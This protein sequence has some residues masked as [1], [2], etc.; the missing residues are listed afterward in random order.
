LTKFEYL[1]P[2][3]VEEASELLM[4]YGE[5]AKIFNGG[6]DLLVRMRESLLKPEYL[7]DIKSISGMS[8]IKYLDGEGLFLGASVTMNQLTDSQEVVNNYYVL[9]E[10]AHT[11]ASY[12]LRN[13]ATLVGNLCNASPS[14]D[15]IPA[16]YVLGAKVKIFGPNGYRIMPVEDFIL[17]VRKI[18]LNKGELVVGV[19]LPRTNHKVYGAYYKQSRRKDVDL[20]TV[21]TAVSYCDKTWKICFAAVAPKPLRVIAAEK[22]LN[23]LSSI[24]EAELQPVLEAA[25]SEVTPI[26]DIRGSR[27]YRIEMIKV[28]LKRAILK[29]WGE[30]N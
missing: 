29:V 28:S 4:K 27:E 2:N 3:S 11:V 8:D 13:R 9:A 24:S 17:G 5:K 6:T 30:I 14:G 7:V 1:K 19:I 23:S 10:S 12:Q 16:L 21:G 22:I 26:T 25:A 18:A 20:A 15:T